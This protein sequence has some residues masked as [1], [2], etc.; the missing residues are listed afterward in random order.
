M[1]GVARGSRGRAERR[2]PSAIRALQQASG[3]VRPELRR[4]RAG[5]LSLSEREEI[6]RGLSAG[7]P[8]RAIA[9]ELGKAP[10]TVC[11]EVSRNDG[12]ARYRACVAER[13]AWRRARRPKAADRS[14]FDVVLID[15]DFEHA[16]ASL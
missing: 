4:R 15:D 11:R 6:S 2:Y 1:S 9:R 5:T 12:A 13:G 10:S 8:L 3:G 16:D 7:H 14:G